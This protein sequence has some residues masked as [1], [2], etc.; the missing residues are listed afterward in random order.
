M[1]NQFSRAVALAVALGISGSASIVWAEEFLKIEGIDGESPRLELRAVPGDTFT[2]VQLKNFA[3][4]DITTT[5]DLVKA[6]SRLVGRILEMEPRQAR[7]M[8]KH[9][10]EALSKR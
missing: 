1:R 7:M 2:P 3:R 9:L 4:H 5:G 8:Q 10:S 6:D